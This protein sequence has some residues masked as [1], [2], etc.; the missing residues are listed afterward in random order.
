[1]HRSLELIKPSSNQLPVCDAVVIADQRELLIL[2]VNC[3]THSCC[4]WFSS[5]RISSSTQEGRMKVMSKLGYTMSIIAMT[6]TLGGSAYAQEQANRRVPTRAE[7]QA[8]YA[9]ENAARAGNEERNEHLPTRAEVQ[10]RYAKENAARAG[11]AKR[12]AWLA[13]QRQ[14]HN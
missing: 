4:R 10:A 3:W 13:S 11:N 8:R 9:K 2:N 1:M 14:T 7:V 6:A 5:G 12:N